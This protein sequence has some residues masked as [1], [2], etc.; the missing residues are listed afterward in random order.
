[1]NESAPLPNDPICVLGMHRSGTSCLA[2]SLET[3]GVHLGDVVNKS[4]H[5]LK[6]NKESKV[7]RQINEDLLQFNGGSWDKLPDNLRWS[8]DLQARRD[9]YLSSF[10]GVR[11]WGFKDPRCLVTLPF[12]RETLGDL[13]LV[14]TVRHPAAVA[15]SLSKR[16]GLAPKT[17]P[18]Q[19]WIDYNRRL[20]EYC[21]NETVYMVCFNWSEPQYLKA[22]KR[23]N[24]VLDLP[25]PDES[26]PF[27]ETQL[28]Q[29]ESTWP[30]VPSAVRQEAETIFRALR[31]HASASL[32]GD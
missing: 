29:S 12:W 24:M 11:L 5:N 20:L 2:G 3:A 8:D 32:K 25:A 31:E 9:A 15:Q 1:M 30:D 4:P 14:G 28:R 22:M 19:L 26:I 17:E 18:V 16:G 23:L 6:G 10:D 13:R 27:F 21:K 7:Q